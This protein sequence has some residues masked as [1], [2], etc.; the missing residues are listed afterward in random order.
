M[1]LTDDESSFGYDCIIC[2]EL[3]ATRLER[4]EHLE[5]HFI[6]KNCT[7]CNR[8][9]IVIGD[10]EFELH[11]PLHC[12]V[13]NVNRDSVVVVERLTLADE[14]SNGEESDDGIVLKEEPPNFE[15]ECNNDQ[16]LDRTTEMAYLP[17][18]LAASIVAN[19][20]QMERPKKRQRKSTAKVKTEPKIDK[21]STENVKKISRL[22]KPIH[23]TQDGCN[24]EFRQ[25]RSFR[26][27]LKNQHGII[28]RVHCLICNFG[29]N[30]K[31]NLKRHM[32]LHTGISFS[33]RLEDYFVFIQ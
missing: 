28:E 19:K 6:H 15:D 25:Q 23:C 31:S 4:S 17:D 32:I 13:S 9:V 16:S 11:R 30:D 18:D 5:S 14:E 1:L 3:F 33:W 24:E 10:I 12:K 21:K 22:S 2:R 26:T 27:H 20:Q 29:F 7:D 8:A